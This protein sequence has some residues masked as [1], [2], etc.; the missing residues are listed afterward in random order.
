V[1]ATGLRDSPAAATGTNKHL[2]ADT[3]TPNASPE[4]DSLTLVATGGKLAESVSGRIDAVGP[5][6]W[7]HHGRIDSL[8]LVATSGKVAASVSER[9]DAVGP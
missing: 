7:I 3:R 1:L 6:R 2:N 8:T 5:D 9:I 4:I